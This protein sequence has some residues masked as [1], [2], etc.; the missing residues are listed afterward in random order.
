MS[1]IEGA[2]SVG[3]GKSSGQL[4]VVGSNPNIMKYKEESP[5]RGESRKGVKG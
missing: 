3:V 2:I 1:M 4:G 5:K